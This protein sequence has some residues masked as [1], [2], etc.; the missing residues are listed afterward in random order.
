MKITLRTPGAG[1]TPGNRYSSG[2]TSR[3]PAPNSSWSPPTTGAVV[4]N[5]GGRY[6]GLRNHSAASIPAA[7]SSSTCFAWTRIPPPGDS[8]SLTA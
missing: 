4:L 5:H 7:R 2:T 1:S 3:S 6:P 8:G